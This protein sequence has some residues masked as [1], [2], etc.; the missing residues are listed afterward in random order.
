MKNHLVIQEATKLKGKAWPTF[1][2]PAQP[3]S[4]RWT[5]GVDFGILD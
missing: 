3:S 5:I 1:L 4:A 2:F